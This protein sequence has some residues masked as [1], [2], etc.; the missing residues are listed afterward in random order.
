MPDPVPCAPAPSRLPR[1]P[2]LLLPLP[3]RP[4]IRRILPHLQ[5]LVRTHRLPGNP[6]VDAPPTRRR[7]A[8]LQHHRPALIRPAPHHDPPALAVH[9]GPDPLQ[10]EQVEGVVAQPLVP[11]RAAEILLDQTGPQVGTER[12]RPLRA[13]AVPL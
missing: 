5:H 12:R 3:A 13:F 4:T 9:P 10:R 1:V 8:P 6:D 2:N 11:T 7:P